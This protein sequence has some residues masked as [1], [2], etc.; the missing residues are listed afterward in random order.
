MNTLFYID[1]ANPAMVNLL[2]I[3]WDESLDWET[4]D[5]SPEIMK[6]LPINFNTEHKNMLSNLHAVVSK[7]YLAS[8]NNLV[9]DPSS[10]KTDVGR[11]Y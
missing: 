5:G 11:S 9:I 8:F 4:G 2:K 3:R 6:I 10:L 7:G 1:G